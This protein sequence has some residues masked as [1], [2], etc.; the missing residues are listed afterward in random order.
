MLIYK[1]TNKINGKSYIGQ[2]VGSLNRR[3]CKHISD[4]LHDNRDNSYLHRAMIKYELKNFTW[5]ILV[6]ICSGFTIERLNELEVFYIKLYNTY[7]DGY[8]LDIGGR[9]VSPSKET[10]MKISKT[11]T[12]RKRSITTRN[13]I[14]KSHKGKKF[15]EEHKLNLSLARKGRY[16]GKNHPMAR[17]VIINNKYFD[18]RKEAAEYLG[19]NPG[20]VR[21]R[22]LQQQ[23]G[24]QYADVV[25]S[26]RTK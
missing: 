5:L 9:S 20:T 13:K 1:V 4:A 26:S 2:T 23:P 12:G 11:M 19:V 3:K 14:A 18:T 21:Y 17:A 7:N 10:R 6:E 8:N 25:C 24:Y 22:I 16:V 15:S